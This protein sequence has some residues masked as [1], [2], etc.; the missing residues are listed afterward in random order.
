[1]FVFDSNSLGLKKS[2]IIRKTIG[3]ITKVMGLESRQDQKVGIMTE[4]HPHGTNSRLSKIQDQVLFEEKLDGAKDGK[5]KSLLKKLRHH[6]FLPI[7]GGRPYAE[8]TAVIFV[9]NTSHITPAIIREASLT[10]SKVKLY[11]VVIGDEGSVLGA[12]QI[13]SSP[14]GIYPLH[15][16]SYEEMASSATSI[17]KALCRL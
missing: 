10:S 16:P 9:D 15:V 13:Y 5:L 14:S 11:V 2:T 4:V 17:A 8:H 1:M 12:D 7:N 6:S 3:K